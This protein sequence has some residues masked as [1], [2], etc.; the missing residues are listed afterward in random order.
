MLELTTSLR[1]STG[2]AA[3][4]GD[5]EIPGY[6]ESEILHEFEGED[7][8][9]QEAE[10]EV[11]GRIENTSS[12]TD[13]L[14][15]AAT[16][17]GNRGY[18]G[19]S[20]STYDSV[21]GIPGH[22]HHEEEGEEEEEEHGEEAVRIG[23]DQKRLDLKA[24]LDV[25][26][27]VE[28]LK[29]R[30]A[31]NDY[32][33]TE[34]EGD[35]IGTVFD[36]KGT[37]LRVEAKHQ[38]FGGLEGAIGAQYKLIDF[39]AIG[40]EAFVPGSETRQFS[41][42]AFEELTL[43]DAW[44]LQGSARLESQ[45]ITSLLLPTH[46]DTAWGASIGAIWSAN[47]F[48]TLS[49][50]LALTERHPN[51]T[52]LYADGPHLAVQRYERGTVTQGLGLLEK[53]KSTNLDLTL[54]GRYDRFEFSVT[55][56]VNNVDDYI[57]LSPTNE[58]EDELQVFDYLQT[59]VELTGFEGELLVDIA[60]TSFGHLHARVFGDYVRGKQKSGGNLPRIPPLRVGGGLH[61]SGDKIDAS[62]EASRYSDQDKLADNELPTDG[63]TMTS[64]EISYNFNEPNVLVFLR[65]TNLG[66]EDARRHTSPLKDIAPLPG[67]SVHL[68]MR[69]NF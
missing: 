30:V 18:V 14:A 9:S 42:F 6:S 65:G 8:G 50:N 20:Y 24:Q 16:V 56:F 19:V 62:I 38:V 26:G 31:K 60:E 3:T 48:L 7:E 46:D 55:G 58:I 13:G 66:N 35:E 49:G 34:F 17:L 51:A 40:D 25:G 52:E 32:G 27:A 2:S 36:T 10:E 64:A 68:G 12:E 22:H 61:L 29:I 4:T 11:F 63:Y 57:L 37:D 5:V 54:R 15:A 44:V 21:Y 67:R 41:L 59:D 23:L 69:W 28:H 45:K 1:I 39:E 53:E 47:D 43:S 33:H